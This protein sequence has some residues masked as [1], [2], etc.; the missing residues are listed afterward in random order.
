MN[1]PGA[2][3]LRNVALIANRGAGKTSLAEAIL[4]TTGAIPSLGSVAQG[5]TVSDFEPEEIHHRSS[6]STSLLR[7]TWNHMTIN[8]LDTPGALSLLGEAI[9][10]LHAVDAVIVVLTPSSGIRSELL[11]LWGFIRALGLPCLMFV[12]ELE[13]ESGSIEDVLAACQR[14]L[15]ITPL[16]MSVILREGGQLQGVMEILG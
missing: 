2:R 8:L 3:S 5:T 16:P 14:D 6:V 13:K 9:T 12:N 10:A 1:E 4:F 7:C 15:E 11:R